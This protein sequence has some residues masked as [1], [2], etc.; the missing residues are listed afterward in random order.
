M[1]NVDLGSL[2]RRVR[3]ARGLSQRQL[4]KLAG[5]PTPPSR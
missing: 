3:E 4:A 5:I 2:L 1:Q